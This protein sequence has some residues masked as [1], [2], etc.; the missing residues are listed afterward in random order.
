ML[1]SKGVTPLMRHIVDPRQKLLFDPLEAWLTEG[2]GLKRIQGSWQGVFR[3]LILKLMPADILGGEFDP[4]LGRPTKEL[5][6]VSGLILI[7]EFMNWTQQE[8]ADRYSLDMGIHYALNLGV[9][10][11]P[12]S[13]R[14]IQRYRK[15]FVENEL[16]ANVM[17]DVTAKLVEITGIKIDEQRLDSTHVFSNM[18]QF[19]RTRL[20]GITVK[21]F[22]TQVKQHNREAYDA[23]PEELR[24]RFA[25]SRGR[26][27]GYVAKDPDARRL[28]RGEVARDMLWLIEHFASDASM[29]DRST[30][31]NLQTVFE[32]QC[33]VVGEKVRVRDRVGNNVIQN[34]SDPDATRE[35]PKGPGHKA[36]LAETS[37]KDNEIQLITAVIPQTG[38]DDD[39][40]AMP[41]VLA[42]LEDQGL[43]PEVLLAD[44]H[45]GSDADQQR[46]AEKDVRLVAPA[47][48]PPNTRD[49]HATNMADFEVDEETHT[50][51]CCPEGHAPDSSEH[52]AKTGKTRTV[53]PADACDNCSRRGDCLVKRTKKA[54][55][56]L[57]HTPAE[58]RLQI[59]R[60]EQET[61]EFRREYARRAGIES[62]NSGLKRR[63]G[64]G[65]LRVR[66]S[67]AVA[68]STR[69]KACGWNIL[70]AA[71]TETV[72]RLVAEIA[73]Q[74]VMEHVFGPIQ[75]LMRPIWLVLVA[76]DRLRRTLTYI[77]ARSPVRA[78]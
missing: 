49:I 36:Q 8:A 21:R 45:Y 9:A 26:M 54:T 60:R 18:A 5:Y 44:T 33:E 50:V 71:A 38:A 62:T 20:M 68:H 10:C 35:G 65:K 56:H 57:Y 16:A 52:N 15:Y 48:T 2:G 53:M 37:N 11:K 47:P 69:M 75:R 74:S 19:G 67:P 12:M 61:D 77:A 70:R 4:S 3:W 59:R 28:L 31:K 42:E 58:R 78:A 24:E 29:T 17:R 66:G 6:S 14:T 7:M 55:Y 13:V 41:V 51:V 25:P 63:L 32:Q 39:R 23:L 40:N 22:L 76:H 72:R 34:P 46:C 27:F 1:E 43:M 64:F 30:Y 73:A